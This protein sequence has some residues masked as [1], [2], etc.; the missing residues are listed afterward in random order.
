[1]GALFIEMNRRLIEYAIQRPGKFN[2]EKMKADAVMQWKQITM[3]HDAFLKEKEAIETQGLRRGNRVSPKSEHSE[4]IQIFTV[5][6]SRNMSKGSLDRRASKIDLSE[7]S[8]GLGFRSRSNDNSDEDDLNA[9][10]PRSPPPG[11]Y[12]R[13]PSMHMNIVDQKVSRKQASS[14]MSSRSNKRRGP[15]RK[16]VKHTKPIDLDERYGNATKKA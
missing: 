12:E 4:G 7:L 3:T 2:L 14:T 1:M 5:P 13:N 10:L 8:G 16:L 6:P 11:V 15:D 9:D